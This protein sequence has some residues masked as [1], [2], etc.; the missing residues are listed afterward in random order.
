MAKENLTETPAIV[1]LA[2]FQRIQTTIIQGSLLIGY[3]WVSLS[4]D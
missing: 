4:I 2:N 1:S 3:L